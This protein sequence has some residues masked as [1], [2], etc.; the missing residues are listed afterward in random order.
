MQ[1]SG[2]TFF[3][4]KTIEVIYRTNI[5]LRSIYMYTEEVV[6]CKH[7]YVRKENEQS[8]DDVPIFY[9]LQACRHWKFG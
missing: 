7:E 1:N 9:T 8:M 4:S 2:K 3:A 6:K 5:N